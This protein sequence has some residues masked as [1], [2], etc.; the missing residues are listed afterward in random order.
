MTPPP[1]PAGGDPA[2]V[3]AP[4]ARR[5]WNA[6]RRAA[7]RRHHPDRGGST[8]ALLEAYAQVDARFGL[9]P[10]GRGGTGTRVEVLAP[11]W[12]RRL[13][14]RL[15]DGA[16][17]VRRPSTRFIDV[18]APPRRESAPRHGGRPS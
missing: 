2:D 15:A 6:E 18:T 1:A 17:R 13:A 16:D 3:L 4:Q 9:A 5:R 8:E 10:P 14:H 12:W 11:P 7:A